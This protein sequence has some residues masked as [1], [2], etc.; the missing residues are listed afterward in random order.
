M[1]DICMG[2]V[3]CLFFII[4]CLSLTSVVAQTKRTVTLEQCDELSY[5]KQGGRSY[6]V[7]RGNVR[8]RHEDVVMYCDSA[9]FYEGGTNSFDAFGNV[10]VNQ[11]SGANMTA[12]SVFYNGQ[13]TLM[14]VR[15]NVVLTSTTSTLKTRFLDFYRNQNYGYYYGGGEVI[16]QNYHLTSYQGYYYTESK[17]Y[18]F[19]DTVVL[20]HPQYIIHAD[21][22]RYNEG[23]GKATL[24]GPSLVRGQ[25][26]RVN[27]SKGWIYTNTNEGRLYNRSVIHYEKG[28]RMT[29]DSIWFNAQSGWVKAFVDVEVQ[30]SLQKMIV[31]GQYIECDSTA[32]AYAK[33]MDHPYVID[34]STNDS[35]YLKADLFHVCEID[36][37]R[38]EF[39]AYQ[40][41]WFYKSDMQGKCDSLVYFVQ[42]SMAKMYKDPIIWSEVNQLTG[43]G[44]I[45]IYLKNK[46]VDKIHI[47]KNA[48][49]IA[50][51]GDSLFNQLSGKKADA[52]LEQSRLRQ[53]DLIG[54]ANSIYYS[55]DNDGLL[56]GMNKAIGPQMSIFTKRNKL[57]KILMTPESEGTMFPPDKIPEEMRF[58]K[59]FKWRVSERPNTLRE[60][61]EK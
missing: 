9:Y 42:D 51:E 37:V 60:F 31:R 7:L 61:F 16:D 3:R 46:K 58:L 59:G 27:T 28:K 35:L 19:K 50:D 6:Q 49:I 40:N 12:D 17:S 4:F 26:Y 39:R 5:D 23:V 20:T 22:L 45:E 2:K 8:F 14:R 33:V 52:F 15:G 44:L 36:S 21:S 32:L 29:A 13:T 1:L 56:V 38:S 57:Q 47:P 10:R 43:D 54:D 25:K 11:Q 41:V 18:L 34:Y 48:L 30:D 53:I 55:K 24:L